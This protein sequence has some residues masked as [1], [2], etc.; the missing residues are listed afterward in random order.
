MNKILGL[1]IDVDTCIGMQNGVPSLL[2]T[3]RGFGI[4]GS[5]YLSIGPDASGRAIFELFRNPRFLKKMLNSNAPGMYGIKTAL[6]GTLLSSP[7]IGLSFPTIVENIINE[8]HDIQFHAWDHRRWQDEVN[9]KDDIWIMDWFANGVEGFE[10]LTGRKPD[11][12]GAPGWVINEK[13]LRA[14]SCFGFKYLSCTRGTKP[15]IHQANEL[16]EIPSDLQCFEEVGISDGVTKIVSLLA[17]G[18]THI[19]PVH[20]EVEGGMCKEQFVE[21]LTMAIDSGYEIKTLAE[22][23]EVTKTTSLPIRNHEMKLLPGRAFLCAV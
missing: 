7:M 11:A 3:L 21:L 19:L 8:G 14:V 12:F 4:K 2:E 6:Y 20:A 10:K 17:N 15:F 18:G 5:F 9:R 23:Y 1:K 22:I 16:V 13:V